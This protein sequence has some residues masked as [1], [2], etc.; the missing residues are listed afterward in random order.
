MTEP[1]GAERPALRCEHLVRR[2]GDRAAVDDVSFTVAPGEAYG[3][4][5]PNGAGK[6]TIISMVAG[7]LE[8]EAGSILV[9][10]LPMR[11]GALSVKAQTGYVPQDIALYPDLSGAEN[12][13]F[14]ASLYRIPRQQA[15]TRVAEVLDV[16]GLT[17]RAGDP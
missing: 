11:P 12:L 15:S 5:G 17:D 6:T 7:V 10:G 1:K 16:V 4:L 2:F 8:T 14:F 13:R 3:L 9:D